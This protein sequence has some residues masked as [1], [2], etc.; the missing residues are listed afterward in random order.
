MRDSR[1]SVGI[2]RPTK[3]SATL[4]GEFQLR[5]EAKVVGTVYHGRGGVGVGGGEELH[6]PGGR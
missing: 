5:C 4:E 2:L 6:A 1:R 3:A